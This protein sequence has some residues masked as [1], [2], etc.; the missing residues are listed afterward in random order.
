VQTPCVQTPAET[1]PAN[2]LRLWFIGACVLGC[3][4]FLAVLAYIFVRYPA[5]GVTP[6][7]DGISANIPRWFGATG[8]SIAYWL[9]GLLIACLYVYTSV[10]GTSE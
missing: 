6:N 7:E 1:R 10:R 3:V 8:S 5:I 4:L 2:V 9:I